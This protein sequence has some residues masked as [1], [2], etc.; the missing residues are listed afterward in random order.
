MNNKTY[1]LIT[2]AS[3]G[4]GKALA[5]RCAERKMNLVLVALPNTG[6]KETA[7]EISEMHGTEVKTCEADLTENNIAEKIH[8]W[9]Q[10]E[11]I[12]NGGFLHKLFSS[13]AMTVAEKAVNQ[14]LREKAVIIPNAADNVVFQI[15]KLIP[16]NFRIA[17]MG[18]IMGMNK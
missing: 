14:F 10:E 7:E 9:C 16:A 15:S 8:Q 17:L 11:R 1:T 2:G 3:S 6:L 18:R 13:K 4:I 12:K 5:L